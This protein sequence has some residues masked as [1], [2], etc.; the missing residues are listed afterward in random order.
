MPSFYGDRSG[1]IDISIYRGIGARGFGWASST[2]SDVS[3][4]YFLYIMGA[5]VINSNN[6]VRRYGLPLRY[7]AR[8]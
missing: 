4:A 7:L 5:N 3:N 2:G 8:Q 1:Y 6:D